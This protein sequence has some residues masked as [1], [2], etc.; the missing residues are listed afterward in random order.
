MQKSKT[1]SKKDRPYSVMPYQKDWPKQYN[2]EEKIINRVFGELAVSI[3][4]IGST[5]VEGMWAKPQID[6]LVIVNDLNTVDPLIQLMESQGYNYQP[7]FCKFNER[8]FTRDAPS[9]ERLVSVHVM[10]PDNP[11]AQS[12]IYLREYLKSH[13]E[14]REIYSRVKKEAYESGADRLEYPQKKQKVL[15][16]ILA[17]AK[18]WYY[19][20]PKQ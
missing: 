13:P 3:E 10:Q 12:H 4:H 11:E 20:Q 5:S 18:K 8:Y 19:K 14:E 6:I 7:E 15:T 1:I 17:A 9:G 16:K 2:H